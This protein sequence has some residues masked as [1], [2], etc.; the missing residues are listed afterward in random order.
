MLIHVKGTKG[1]KNRYTNTILS[2][3]ALE[4]LKEYWRQYKPKKWLF[5]SLKPSRRISTRTVDKILEYACQKSNIK[6]DISV[7]SLR[8]SFYVVDTPSGLHIY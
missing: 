7:H 5:E 8:R 4:D 2:D 1:R 3:T 6:K